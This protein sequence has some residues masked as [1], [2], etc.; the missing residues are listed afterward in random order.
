MLT[1]CPRL[2]FNT[3][4]PKEYD[5]DTERAV[6]VT[7]NLRDAPGSKVMAGGFTSMATGGAILAV[8]V[9]VSSSATLVTVLVT[10]W[11]PARCEIAIEGVLRL[12]GW[13]ILKLQGDLV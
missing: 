8:I 10:M 6:N 1:L 7:E 13:P 2:P 5:P 3:T 11:V 9:Y 12:D 4:W